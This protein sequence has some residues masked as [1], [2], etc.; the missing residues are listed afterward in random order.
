MINRRQGLKGASAVVLAAAMG[1]TLTKPASSQTRADTLR[2]VMGGAVNTLDPTTPGSTRETYGVAMGVYDR[3]ARFGVHNV[4]GNVL[5]D[6]KSITGELAEKVERLENDK[7]LV[8]HIRDGAKW[9]DGTPVTAQDVKWSLDRH[10]SA[11]T[12]AGAQL[13]TGSL[14]KPEQFR[15]VGDRTV[16]IINEVG[17]RLALANTC[18][19]YAIMINSTLA[20]KNA[21]ADDPWAI[22][23]L[24]DNTAAGGAY[25]VESFQSS[26]DI[27]LRRNEAWINGKKPHFARVVVQTVPEVATRTNLVQRGG[28]DVCLD[29]QAID[30]ANL[31]R[32]K[33]FK[34]ASIPMANAFHAL[35]LNNRLP[36]F[37]NPKVRKSIAAALPYDDIYKAAVFGRGKPLYGASWTSPPDASFPQPFPQNDNVET[38]RKLLAEAGHPNGFATTFSYPT[39]YATVADPMSALIKEALARIKIDVTI[40]KLPDAQFSTLEVERRMPFFMEFG[41]AWL[42]STDYFYRI[43]MVGDQRWNWSGY[44]SKEINDMVQSLRFES[45]AKRYEEGCRRIIEISAQD[46]PMIFLWQ[47]TLDVVMNAELD[48]FVYYPHRQIDYRDIKRG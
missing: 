2:Q 17:D 41:T 45:D 1:N 44:D 36:P 28:A 48:G 8:F 21:S 19:P 14:T 43:F 30:V 24:K 15:I 20:K 39:A 47:P 32:D 34:V 38:A 6:F 7:R 12:L 26:R 42:P 18:V 5:Y 33:R 9:H 10:V 46:T 4:D 23:W 31:A 37:D 29:L 25:T 35:I 11:R 27:S 16:E 40:Q 13:G 22:N 3:L